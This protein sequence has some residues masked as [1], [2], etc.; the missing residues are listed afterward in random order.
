MND[1]PAYKDR[2]NGQMAPGDPN[3]KNNLTIHWDAE[4]QGVSLSCSAGDFKNWLFVIAVLDMA[5]AAAEQSHKMQ[6]AQQMQAMQMQAMQDQQIARQMAKKP[7]LR[8]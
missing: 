7:L 4:A 8:G 2:P 3:A 1:V 6:I 5:K